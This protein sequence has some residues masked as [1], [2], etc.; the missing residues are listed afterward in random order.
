MT[1]VNTTFEGRSVASGGTWKLSDG[2]Q[3]TGQ[4]VLTIIPEGDVTVTTLTGIAFEVDDY[5]FKSERN[6]DTLKAGIPYFAGDNSCFTN[7][8][9]SGADVVLYK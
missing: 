6:L 3:L 2:D 9:F 4:K 5:D 7:L 8:K 1:Q